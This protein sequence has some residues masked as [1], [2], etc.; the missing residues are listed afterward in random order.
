MKQITP[1]TVILLL[2]LLAACFFSCKK[3]PIEEP[4]NPPV[5]EISRGIYVLSEGLKD[6]NNSILT[7]YDFD[8]GTT[9]DAFLAANSRGLGDTGN[10]L[11]IYGSKMYCVVNVSET[12]EIMDLKTAKS[13]KQISLSG[14]SPRRIAFADG[15]A[16]VCCFDGAVVKIDTS[17]MSVTATAQAGSN[18]DGICTA[19]G[20]LYVSNSGGLNYPN[21]GNTVTVFDLATF[22]P[23]KEIPV[24]I[25]PT[26]IASDSQ[27]DV[28]VVSNGNYGSVPMTFQRIDS[29][30]DEVIQTFDFSVTN[31]AI[32]GDLCY[33][34]HYNYSTEQYSLKVM[35][36]LTEQIVNEQFV[37]DG[38]TLRTPYGIAVNPENGEVYLTDAYQYTTNGDVFCFGSDGRMKFSFEAGI[39]PSCI[40]FKQ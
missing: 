7:F 17:T 31:F 13:L 12:V 16:Y 2:P 27:G 18:P 26:R 35:N 3:D 23:I 33:F 10:D 6:H 14:R 39:C 1:K 37:T 25:N 19:N 40:V 4:E 8:Q 11:Q 36:V 38:T 30:I 34:Y 21:Y 5:E 20:K 28:Y 29:Q 24:V 15:Y 9:T 22:S 32:C